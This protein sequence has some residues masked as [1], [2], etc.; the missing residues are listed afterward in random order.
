MEA[1]ADLRLTPDE[2]FELYAGQR[3]ELVDGRASAMA[4]GSR[5]HA[6]VTSNIHASLWLRL[7]GTPC[8]AYNSDMAVRTE[9]DTIRYPDIT[10]I[11]DEKE[12]GDEAGKQ[13]ALI[14]P[15]VLIE[16][17]SPSTER[18]DRFVKLDEYKALPSV[19]TIVL[20][21][22]EE[23]RFDTFERHGEREWLNTVRLPGSSL[24]LRDPEVTVT[25][26][27]MFYGL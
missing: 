1:L 6:Q 12:L 11:C 9:Q 15:K 2:F 10:I 17:R 8:R 19:D 7:R 22:P 13:F 20:V 23:R 27:E 24:N 25:A 4:G 18:D 14:A 5:L 16:V 26:D 21:H 3:F